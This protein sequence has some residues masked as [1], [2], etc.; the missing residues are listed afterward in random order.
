[1][2]ETTVDLSLPPA[3]RW[4]LTPDQREQA[5]ELLALYQADLGLTPDLAAH[6]AAAARPLIP[7]EQW[8]EV[9]ALAGQCE[10][11]LTGIAT[12]NLYYDA[13]KFVIGCTAFAVD[14]PAGPLHA[15]NLDWWTQND[16]LARYTLVTRFTGGPAGDFTTA[17]W[18]GFIGAFSGVAPGRFAVTLNAV[19]S[20]EPMRPAIPVV[21]LLRHTLE[22][23][24]DFAQALRLL[25]ETPVPSDSLLLL[26]G[27]RRGEM[28][29]IERT[30]TRHATRHPQ[31]GALCVTNDYHLID[32]NTGLANSELQA[33][34]CGRYERI[35]TLV[36]RAT[37][38][39][40]EECFAYLNDPAVRMGITVQQMVF[41]A[42]SGLAQVR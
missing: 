3:Q 27:T 5:R 26:T 1:M 15:R 40:A 29:V 9:E 37:P 33:T 18:P 30:P 13:L 19:L 25:S 16:M 34:S 24:R 36:E 23:A 21:F 11:P 6:L 10:V 12:A 4:R 42:A 17:G 8:A 31:Q 32:A 14:T 41:S 35:R 2:T 39:N 20:L 22:N 28:A 38:E 7:T